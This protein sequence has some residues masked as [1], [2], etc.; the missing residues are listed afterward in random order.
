MWTR[1]RIA[2]FLDH[3]GNIPEYKQSQLWVRGRKYLGR[4]VPEGFFRIQDFCVSQGVST[5][6]LVPDLT[7]T[8]Q[9]AEYL[10]QHATG[11]YPDLLTREGI[12]Q[13]MG[14]LNMA[15]YFERGALRQFPDLQ[16]VIKEELL[17]LPNG[18]EV[19]DQI[20]QIPEY[21]DLFK[22]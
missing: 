11:K 21:E 10:I 7:Y 15:R 13:A 5:D 20:S 18:K 17:K 14:Y 3:S 9:G 1:E 2:P 16:T 22:S 8:L 6:S 4:D 19:L 12:R